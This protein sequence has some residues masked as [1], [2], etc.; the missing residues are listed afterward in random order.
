L[1]GKMIIVKITM[2]NP[3]LVFIP[4]TRFQPFFEDGFV[5]RNI[6]QY[7]IMSDVIEAPFDIRFKY[8]SRRHVPTEREE[9]AGLTRSV[10]ITLM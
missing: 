8:P 9:S 2:V 7:P 5:D 4:V 6:F 10:F 1:I 3:P